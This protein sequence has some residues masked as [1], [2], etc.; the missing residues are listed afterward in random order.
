MESVSCGP[1]PENPK[2]ALV[3]PITPPGCDQPFAVL[4]A[5]VSAR[6]PLNEFYR[7]FYDL[8]VAAVTS[9]VANARAHEEQRQRSEALAQVDR[10]KTA[11][12][13]NVSHEF[14]TPLTLMLGPLEEEL[15]EKASPLPADRR[16]RLDM[17]HRNALRLLKLVNNLLD[18][19][20]IEAGRINASYEPTDLAAS[21]AE[22]AS[23]FRSAI[24]KGGLSLTVDCPPLPEPVYI[25][26]E[27]WE[28]I[29]LNL[30]S[31]A[32]KHTFVGGIRVSLK[33]CGDCAELS[34]ADS[35]VGIP[36]EFL[37]SMSH[38][39]RTPMNGIIGMTDLVLDTELEREQREYLGM[40][41]N[42]A[43]SLLG[44]IN[45]IL[46]FSKI[47]AGKLEIEAISFSLRDRLGR[48]LKPLGI[49]AEQKGLELTVDVLPEVPDLLIGDPM[50]LRQILINLTDNAI[51]FTEHGDVMVRVTVESA[52][53]A[54]HCTALF[55]KRYRYR[56]TGGE[57]VADL[58]GVRAGGRLDDQDHG[59]TGLGVSNC[60]AAGTSDGY[61]STA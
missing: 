14:R 11:F 24:K 45:D 41:K 44:L 19:S 32:L 1:Y 42:S 10:A 53:E 22:L 38:E 8:I 5:G 51:K 17:A 13:S 3:F 54:K 30:L 2:T 59:G 60:F 21:T 28:K 20:S 58:R 55:S 7:H 15:G 37:A 29:V 34:V 57:A 9:T 61:F 12:F 33:W 6:L 40:A 27:M 16:E 49:R 48:M 25:D 18:F 50:R 4:V 46:D 36:S 23:A 47:E 52:T 43:L 35:G 56:H 26:R 39:I 31:N